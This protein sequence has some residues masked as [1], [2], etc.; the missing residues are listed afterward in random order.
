MAQNLTDRN[1]RVIGKIVTQGNL[2]ILL[3]HRG[4]R[5]GHYDS[6]TDT[7]I[8]GNGR[9]FARGDQLTRLL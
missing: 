2:D 9:L 1:G 5:I 4:Y 7:T 3:D 8:D 6:N